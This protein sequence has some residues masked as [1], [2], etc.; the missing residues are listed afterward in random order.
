MSQDQLAQLE[1]LVIRGQ[2]ETQEQLARLAQ[3]VAPG[4]PDQ[5]VSP[6]IQDRREPMVPRR[7][8]VQQATLDLLG[9]Q[10]T[11]GQLD[12]QETLVLLALQAILER[13]A[14]LETLV[15]RE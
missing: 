4:T 14:R 10:E 3:L 13:L 12:R 9:R 8:R 15:R 7:I 11:P 6:A 1:I 2:L 5:L